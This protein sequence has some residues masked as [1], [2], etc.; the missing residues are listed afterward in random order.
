MK[1]FLVL[2]TVLCL[3][4]ALAVCASAATVYVKDGGTGSGLTPESP[5]GN[6]GAAFSTLQGKGG[7]VCLV[8]DTTLAEIITVPDQESDLLITAQNGARLVYSTGCRMQFAKNKNNNVITIDLPFSLA[9]DWYMFG[10]FNN[11]VFTERA[12]MKGGTLFFYGGVMTNEAITIRDCITTIPYSITVHEGTFGQF[13]A[14]NLRQAVANFIG[15]IA[16]PVTVTVTGGTFGKADTVLAA[17]VACE[18]PAVAPLKQFQG[19]SVGGMG[20]VADDVTLDI[21]GGTF[22]MPIYISGRIGTTHSPAQSV[23]AFVAT[24]R[25]YY[26]QDGDVA[27]NISGGTFL[28]G[29]V[30]DTYVDA[31]Y[32]RLMRG[33]YTVTVTGGTFAEGTVF[34]A[35]QV[36]AYAGENKKATI[37]VAEGV[38]NITPR[39]FDVVNGEAV[40]YAEPTRV[41]FIGDSITEAHSSGNAN[42]Q[43]YPAAFLKTAVANGKDVIVSNLGV[44]A[45]G[46]LPNTKYYYPDMLP[47]PLAL[48]ETD[49]DY[50]FF[51]LGTNDA[52]AAGES[53]GAEKLYV[54]GYTAFIKAVGD[55][56]ETDGVYVSSALLRGRGTGVFSMRATAAMRPMQKQIAEALMALD[57]KKYHYVDLYA[58]TYDEAIVYETD[59]EGNESSPFFAADDL[60]PHAGGYTVMG[61]CVYDAI[62]DGVYGV[63]GFA[64]TDVYLS[65]SGRQFGA[66][67]REDPTSSLPIALSKCAPNATLHIVGTST[68]DLRVTFPRDLGKLTVVGEGEGAKWYFT[69]ASL[70]YFDC[71]VVID[72]LLLEIAAPHYMEIFGKYNNVTFGEGFTTA[73]DVRF[74]AG[75]PLYME[76]SLVNVYNT[77]E[78][79]TAETASSDKD[80]TVDIRGGT[81]KWLSAGNRRRKDNSPF[82]TYSGNM[83][84]KLGAGVTVTNADFSGIVGMNYL[85]GSITAEVDGWGAIPLCDYAPIG[86]TYILPYSYKRNT[87]KITVTADEAVTAPRVVMGDFSGDGAFTVADALAAIRAIADGNV[88]NASTHLFGAEKL[89]LTDV[90]WLLRRMAG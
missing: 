84:L 85:T 89:D 68:W 61:Q 6:L 49:A 21:S 82:G 14:G 71:D 70:L 77:S 27:I 20:F 24:D 64:M 19:F 39:R 15:S 22:Y 30:C 43:S 46:M 63:D 90:L 59:A 52:Y 29:A 47:Y 87:G 25:K 4:L 72:D 42:T 86:A 8:G 10:G 81:F 51:A 16:A 38:E 9:A 88:G 74:S 57:A 67:T 41:V 78:I 50:F 62:Y 13:A 34:D 69:G 26:A 17:E 31:G 12:V 44:S 53:R 80:C 23:S 54:D 1:K 36:K 55:L 58:L 2:V 45:S 7:T 60:H 48:E 73:G 66:G 28:G 35:T 75:F 5:V 11:I 37:T 79:D 40:E 3:A 65:D 76:Q 18:N 32:S 83:T 56:P 33:D